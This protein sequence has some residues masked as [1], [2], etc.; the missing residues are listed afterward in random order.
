MG[1]ASAASDRVDG[2][3]GFDNEGNKRASVAEDGRL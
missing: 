2:V 1:R 3:G